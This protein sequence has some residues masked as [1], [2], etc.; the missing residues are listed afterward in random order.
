MSASTRK[1]APTHHRPA[2]K[3]PK[4]KLQPTSAAGASRRSQPASS[5]A[6]APSISQTKTGKVSQRTGK[7]SNGGK[8]SADSA[9]ATSATAKRRH[10]HRTMTR[11]AKDRNVVALRSG[12][13]SALQPP[14]NQGDEGRGAAG[15][16]QA[17]DARRAAEGRYSAAGALPSD[18][19]W[20]RRRGSR[21]P[22]RRLE[23]LSR[24]MRRGSASR[25]SNS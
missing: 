3:K 18:G 19:G 14:A 16:G 25:I 20:R 6:V 13:S 2:R 1:A 12:A 4:P 17:S 15:R 11:L 7:A 9:P 10:P 5:A 8:A 23:I 24:L 22:A 21:G